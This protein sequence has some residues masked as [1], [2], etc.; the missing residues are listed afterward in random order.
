M[1]F[2]AAVIIVSTLEMLNMLKN[3]DVMPHAGLTL[4]GPLLLYAA[5]Y[6]QNMQLFGGLLTL[7][8]VLHLVYLVSQYPKFT[9]NHAAGGLFVT[10]YVSLLIYIYLI[11]ILPAGRSWLF[12]MLLGTWASDTFAYFAGRAFGKHKL[13]P[14]LSPKKTWE[15]AAGGVLGT[16]LI[17]Y[18]YSKLV[19]DVS[20]GLVL[21]LGGLI[22]LAAQIGDLIESAVK[23]QCAIKDSGN[24]IPGH[25]GMLDRFDSMLLTAPLVYYFVLV[26]II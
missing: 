18:I 25:G 14:I 7:I 13:T 17:V 26:F 4:L 23:R 12:V 15:G 5:V 1:L 10:L 3:I 6:M 20:F 19:L 22:S 16:I 8:I 11:S 2:T 21:L 24:I 9:V